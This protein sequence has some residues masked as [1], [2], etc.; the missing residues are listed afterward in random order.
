M[1]SPQLTIDGRE[2]ARI[3]PT[4]APTHEQPHLFAFAPGIRGQLA[5]D[6]DQPTH[7]PMRPRATVRHRGEWS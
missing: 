7:E 2:T 4:D 5:L 1:H 3:A 6:T